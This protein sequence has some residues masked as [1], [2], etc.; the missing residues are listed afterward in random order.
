MGATSEKTP[1]GKGIDHRDRV[2]RPRVNRVIYLVFVFALFSF[3]SLLI[4]ERHVSIWSVFKGNTEDGNQY[5]D[6]EP[7][8]ES[9]VFQIKHIFHHGIGPD[10]YRV[11]KRLDVTPKMA[12]DLEV[13]FRASAHQTVVDE[14]NFEETLLVLDWPHSLENSSPWTVELKA[15]AAAS[16]S[17]AFRLKQR[18]RPD[19]I[20]SYLWSSIVASEREQEV[21]ESALEWEEEEVEVPDV[22]D[23]D[24]VLSLAI[25]SSNAYVKD[26]EKSDNSEDWIDLGDTWVPDKHHKNLGYG[27]KNDSLRGH[28]FVSKDNRTVV[29]AI[30]GTSAPGLLG[31]GSKDTVANDKLNDNLL[32]LCCCARVSYL[33]SPVCDCYQK[34]YTCGQNCIELE[35]LRKDRYYQATLDLYRNVT[36]IYPPENTTIW[37]TG[38]SMGGSLAS[39]LGRTFGLPAV[40]YEAPGEMLA[41]KRLHLPQ[42]PGLPKEWENIWHFGNT[43]D[44]IYMGVCNGV[45]SSC[46]TAGYAMETAC[47]TGKQCVYDVVTDKGWSVSLLNH[48]IHTVIDDVITD[49]N[50]T[51][52]CVDQAPCHDCF[53]WRYV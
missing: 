18:H 46:N 10:Y 9:S 24:T 36:A 22:Q 35:L 13:D 32:F 15:K 34:T 50:T 17:K 27:W 30:K 33:W 39:L 51:P 6:T 21:R 44:P 40:A 20:E 25:M 42:P 4:G 37:V 8:S 5:R 26:K 49:Y 28:V 52:P 3:A 11:H 1:L 19:F 23:L 45:S 7:T 41:V 12:K 43:G 38:H 53:N 14:N 47:H 31:S 29:I 16:K 2:R 48:R